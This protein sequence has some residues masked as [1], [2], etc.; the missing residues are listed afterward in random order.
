MA[1]LSYS[2]TTKAVGA[3]Q[4]LNLWEVQFQFPQISIP[5]N[6]RFR[7]VS[8]AIPDS[9]EETVSATVNRFELKQPAQIKRNGEIKL[10]FTESEKAETVKLANE[11]ENIRFSMSDKDAE[12]ISAGWENIKGTVTLYLLDNKGN[13]TQGYKLIDSWLRPS[14]SQD[15]GSDAEAMQMD[16]TVNY[17]WWNYINQ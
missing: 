10:K 13:R 8:A 17:N 9:D 16:I 11:L 7:C 3:F 2:T 1:M 5:D 6:V 14:Y 15:L 4:Q 12:G